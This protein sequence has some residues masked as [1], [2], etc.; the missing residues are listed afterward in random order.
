M[1]Y[2]Y[3]LCYV[4]RLGVVSMLCKTLSF[5]FNFIIFMFVSLLGCTLPH[6]EQIF[7]ILLCVKWSSSYWV[8]V[9]FCTQK[10]GM[11]QVH[12]AKTHLHMRIFSCCRKC[13]W[14]W[15]FK[16]AS[17]GTMKCIALALSYLCQIQPVDWLG[18]STEL[19]SSGVHNFLAL[20]FSYT[21]CFPNGV[22]RKPR[23]TW[24]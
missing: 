17:F 12:A 9:Q 20:V 8:R 1:L 18:N 11:L 16:D 14:F 2:G 21:R 15:N 23:V 6:A 22:P 5:S 19:Y 4:P 13:W 24:S 7:K 10:E 3:G